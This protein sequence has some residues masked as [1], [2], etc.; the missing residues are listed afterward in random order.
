M[1]A[2][3]DES[4]MGPREQ[5]QSAQAKTQPSFMLVP[6]QGGDP[7]VL[8][9]MIY[10]LG[11]SRR[12]D[13]QLRSRAVSKLHAILLNSG[14]VLMV[15]DLASTNGTRV[16]GQ[17]IHQ[18]ILLPGDKIAFG[19]MKFRIELADSPGVDLEKTECMDQVPKIDLS[20]NSP[21]IKVVPAPRKN[22]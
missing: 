8:D 17:K 21:I 4:L 14:G 2:F 13:I 18:G 16:N 15:R 22:R 9:R 1:D 12:A 7:V 11:R 6:L 10:V 19:D 20:E 5:P 3:G